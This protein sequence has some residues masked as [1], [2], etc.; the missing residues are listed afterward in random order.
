VQCQFRFD[1]GEAGLW[2][3]QRVYALDEGNARTFTTAEL[4]AAGF[5][6]E[7]TVTAVP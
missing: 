6:T 1:A 4:A 5:R 7:F 2:R 3:V